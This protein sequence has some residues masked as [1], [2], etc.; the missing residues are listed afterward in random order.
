MTMP[1]KLASVLEIARHY[2]RLSDSW[3]IDSLVSPIAGPSIG[4]PVP[5]RPIHADGILLCSEAE[6]ILI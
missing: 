2:L 4:K 1:H 6:L 3:T 5:L